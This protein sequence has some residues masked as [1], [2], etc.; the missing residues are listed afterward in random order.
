[1]NA[2]RSAPACWPT[3]TK[4][5]AWKR[6][7]RSASRWSNRHRSAAQRRQQPAVDGNETEE[8]ESHAGKLARARALAEEETAERQGAHRDEEGDKQQIGSPRRRQDAEIDDIGER[9]AEQR[10]AAERAPDQRAGGA[11]RH[12]AGRP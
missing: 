10:E 2:W 11:R 7:A 3:R 5:G 6:C 12:E 8:D 1:M 9:R 4:P